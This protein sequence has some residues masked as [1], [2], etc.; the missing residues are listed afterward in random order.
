MQE[1]YPACMARLPQPVHPDE[2]TS[3]APEDLELLR[4]FLSLH[5][6]ERGR[7]E[8]LEPSVASMRWWLREHGLGGGRGRIATDDIAWAL[9]VRDALR[10]R[11]RERMDGSPTD[12]AT[13]RTLDQAAR[14]CGLWPSFARSPGEALRVEAAGVRGAVGR[15]LGAAFLAELDGRWERFRICGDPECGSVFY[16][17]ST[18]RSGRWCLMSVCGNRAKAR[19]FRARQASPRAH[20]E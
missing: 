19:A 20:R 15:L 12:P 17:R 7:P 4:S 10:A 5:D 11:V 14:D 16:D 8:G 2:D 13:A 3:P 6:H 9:R 1:C 18:N